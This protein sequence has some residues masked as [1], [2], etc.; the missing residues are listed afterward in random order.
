MATD[1]VEILLEVANSD[2]HPIRRRR[3]VLLMLLL[4]DAGLSPGEAVSLTVSDINL[5][6]G[7][8]LAGRGRRRRIVPLTSRLA[9]ALEEYITVA[10]YGSGWLFPGKKGVMTAR[11]AHQ[12]ISRLAA[13]AG[14]KVA[15]KELTESFYVRLAEK[16]VGAEAL[17]AL[18]GVSML[19]SVRRYSAP[20][21]INELRNFIGLLESKEF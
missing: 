20:P 12:I 18:R 13:R 17:A 19:D 11:G 15:P 3:N 2:S 14:I 7:Y 21:G 4:A 6:Q 8:L 1:A 5:E 9:K 10:K 16:G